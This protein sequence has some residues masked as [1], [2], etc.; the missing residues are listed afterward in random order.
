MGGITLETK[1]RGIQCTNEITK[2]APFPGAVIRGGGG[3]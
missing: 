1:V 2:A 3:P